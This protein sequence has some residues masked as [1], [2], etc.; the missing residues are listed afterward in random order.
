[1][2]LIVQHNSIRAAPVHQTKSRKATPQLSNCCRD[3]TQTSILSKKKGK[4]DREKDEAAEPVQSGGVDDPFD[5][6]SLETGILKA[7]EKLKNDLSKL[8][9]GGRFN[10]EQ[11]ENVKVHLRKES[12]DSIKLGELAQVLPKGGRSLMVLVGEKDV[13]LEF[14]TLYQLLLI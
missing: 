6:S 4:S 1:M 3:F 9:T 13:G 5:Y 2:R 7:L 14:L 10:P 8:R 12:K 11:L